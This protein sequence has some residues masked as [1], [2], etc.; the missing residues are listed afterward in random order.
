[1]GRKNKSALQ[2]PDPERRKGRG[3]HNEEASKRTS[4][5]DREDRHFEGGGKTPGREAKL[6]RGK[7]E[8]L[9]EVGYNWRKASLKCEEEE[10]VIR[11]SAVGMK[12]LY[13]TR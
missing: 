5:W 2:F 12:R 11:K 1:V 3:T 13:K 6:A 10:I 4:F 7:A 8:G 9:K